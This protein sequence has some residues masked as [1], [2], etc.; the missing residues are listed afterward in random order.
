MMNGGTSLCR[1]DDIVDGGALAI[2]TVADAGGSASDLLLL[3]RG[4]RVH[5]YLNICPHAGRRLDYAP[6]RFLIRADRLICAAHG[7]TFDVSTGTCV[8]GPGGGSLSAVPVRVDDAGNVR[9]A[10]TDEA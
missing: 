10:D 1:I 3:R 5:A 2:E 6:G 8:G 9:L 4:D 7:A